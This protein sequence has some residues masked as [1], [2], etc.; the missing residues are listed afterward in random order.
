M[1]WWCTGVRWRVGGGPALGWY[2]EGKGERESPLAFGDVLAFRAVGGRR[3][4]GVWR[5]GRRTPCPAAAVLSGRGTRAQCAEC[6]GIDRAHSVAA[7]TMAD[8]PRPY[9]VYLAWFGSGM[10]KVGIT[11]VGRGP[12]RLLEQGAVAF[13]WLGRGPLMAARRA[14][15][16]LR[17]ALGVPDRIPYAQKRAVRAALP[18]AGERAGELARAHATAVALAGWPESLERLPCEV[19]DHAEVFGI[20]GGVDGAAGGGRLGGVGSVVSELVEGGVV[21]GTLVAAAGPDLHLVERMG[22]PPLERSR[23]L[24]EGRRLVVDT[25]LL[26]G[27]QLEALGKSEREAADVV[28]SVPVKPVKEAPALQGGLF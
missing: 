15:E 8:D 14:E 26:G 1:T 6:A 18:P 3:C 4:L 20:E 19:V 24:G 9:H 16:L 2:G 12:A 13:T 11:G 7:D 5:G 23:E 10:V 21:V 27:W 22:S 17:S 25:R 28:T